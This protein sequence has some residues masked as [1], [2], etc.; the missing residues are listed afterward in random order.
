MSAPAPGRDRT[1]PQWG[2][3]LNE[4][5]YAAL[6][7]SWITRELAE[8][9]M[10]RR[11]DTYEGR[12]VVGQKGNRDCSGVLI[13]YYWPGEASAHTYR[14]R[15]DKP[16]MRQGTDGKTKPAAKYLAPP[17]GGNRLYVPPGVTLEQ[18]QDVTIPIVIVEGEKKALAL[19]RLAN[20]GVSTP[21]FIPVAIAGVWNW[22]GKIGKT[23][24]PKGERLDVHGP[25]ADLSRI[26]W[27][28]RVA[29]I[30]FDTNVYTIESVQWA[31]KGICQEL[32]IRTAEVK[33]VNLPED[34]DVN[35][36][37][38]LLSAQGPDRVLELFDAAV[39]GARLR[40]V[41]P[42]QFQ[43]RPEGMFRITTNGGL[44][45]I[46]LTN[47]KAKVITNIQ[48]DD[49]VESRREFE[50]EAELMGRT[51]RF[52]VSASEFGSMDWPIER[53]GSSAITYPNRKDFARAAIQS[54]SMTAEERSIYTHTG[55]RKLSGVWVYLHAGGAIGAAGPV[56]DVNMRLLGAL[57]R[58]ELRAPTNT[59]AVRVAVK[60]SLRLV[61][62][63]PPSISFP[64]LAATCRAVLG[65]ADFSLHLV[66][67]T[68]AFKS[69]L[70]A[71][72]Q[73]HFGVAM[74]RKNLPGAW[75]S[76]GNSLEV[77]SFHAKDTLLVIDDFAPQGSSNEVARYHAAADRVFRAAGN[78]A[79]RG[80]LDSTS[81][82][83]EAKP[84]RALILSTG[85]EIPRGQSVRARL[86]ILEISKGD[87][88]VTKLTECQKDAYAGL[89]AEAISA[90]IKWLAGR[91]EEACAA[92]ERKVSE[93]R[94][95]ALS[96]MAHARTPDIVANLQAGFDLYLDF[97]VDAGILAAA[98][99]DHLSRRCWEAL[100]EAAA[101]QAKHQGESEPTAK[102]LT[103][104]RSLLTSGRAHLAARNGG[105]PGR[106]PESCGWSRENSNWIPH[107]DRVGW[108]DDD[109]LYLDL[110]AAYRL[111]QIA[112]RDAGEVLA[113][114]EPTLKKRLSERG[115]LASVEKKR[116]TL[117]VR[118]SIGGS[119]KDVLH[120]L[121]GVVLPEESDGDED[122]G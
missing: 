119:Y 53:L 57:S 54:F 104:L 81:K 83:R 121:R 70:A 59:S 65:D 32:T 61:E 102:F 56:S 41:L 21:R 113:V 12:E 86:F 94:A 7:K 47:F 42:P 107:G 122:A 98:E 72:Q 112:G 79:G 33:L 63:G 8:E 35:G 62:L 24:G 111:A 16:E 46:Q 19:W 101:A 28:G 20:H 44:S 36:V 95:T 88:S 116:G 50:I 103:I 110:T 74:I 115:L 51:F 2:S 87:I 99:R 109:N 40:V 18:L 60:A 66:G 114:S 22:K 67:A 100:R 85:E 25:I 92:L 1:P 118:R 73:Q 34:C 52:P 71:L 82:L 30:V 27:R 58:Y 5:D 89:Y 120:F 14:L 97:A 4:D 10:L 17:G 90:F 76:T 93:H 15:R 39:S 29:F 9:A 96:N 45:Q 11:V 48:L 64:L 69:E 108:V 6:A 37:D 26:E 106:A 49:G 13:P 75:S 68:G 55:W 77:L 31:R 3:P 38:D 78:H 117:T 80:R 43:S 23:G 84:P 105:E 91:Y